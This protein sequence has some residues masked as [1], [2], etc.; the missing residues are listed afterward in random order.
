[1]L[2]LGAGEEVHEIDNTILMYITG[3]QD[4]GGGEVLL[5]CCAV[6]ILRRSN[7]EVPA[8]VLIEHAAE[9]RG[10]I[11]VRPELGVGELCLS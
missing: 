11:E 4:I 6:E 10:R 3:L 1:M 8:F 5:L 7:T 9:D 2:A